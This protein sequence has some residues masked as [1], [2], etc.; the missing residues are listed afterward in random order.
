MALN[1]TETNE[2]EKLVRNEIKKFMK[3]NQILDI[4]SNEVKKELNNK[5]YD[6]KIIDLS[7]KIV[8]ELFKTM[9]QRKSF[10]E[11]AIKKV[12]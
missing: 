1:A 4:V 11:D 10:W 9:W 7:S 3:T 2:V 12:K 8:V 6:D 5:K